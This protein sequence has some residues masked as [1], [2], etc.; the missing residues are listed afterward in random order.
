MQRSKAASTQHLLVGPWTH[1]GVFRPVQT[2]RDLDFTPKSVVD[3]DEVHLRWFDHWLKGIDNGLLD[4]APVRYFL[5]GVNEW[6][7]GEAWPP[8][9]SEDHALFLRSSGRANTSLG[10]GTLSPEPPSGDEPADVYRYD[11]ADISHV[12][13][14]NFFDGGVRIAAQPADARGQ[15]LRD[16]ILVYTSEPMPEPLHVVGRPTVVLYAS[17]DCPDTD[18]VVGLADVDP[19]GR[20]IPLMRDEDHQELVS[21]GGRLR[22]RFREGLDSEVFM[23]PGEVY[24]FRIELRDIA[25]VVRPGHRIR[26]TVMSSDFPQSTRNLNTDE[27]I[28]DGT[29]IR[30]ATNS[31]HH[32]P[33]ASSALLLPVLR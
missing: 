11:P 12:A 23:T 33:R 14:V 2:V 5:T 10:D 27:S 9:D 15:E 19:T 24:E 4:E 16:D 17:S 8:R 13:G 22:A 26:L 29:E 32:T 21:Q 28:A 7:E 31:V 1:G 18:W 25:H 3:M 20:S 30:V 6:R